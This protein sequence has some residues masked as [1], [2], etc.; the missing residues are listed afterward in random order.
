MP[1]GR[2]SPDEAWLRRA[3]ARRGRPLAGRR[4][5]QLDPER[6]P[7]HPGDAGMKRRRIPRSTPAGMELNRGPRV[8]VGV[9]GVQVTLRIDRHRHLLEPELAREIA[10]WLGDAAVL[11][12]GRMSSDSRP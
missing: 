7:D 4:A 9:L 2:S 10:R 11:V 5:T 1:T 6:A 3:A 12:E 8:T